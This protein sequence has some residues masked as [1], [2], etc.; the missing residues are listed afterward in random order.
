[1]EPIKARLVNIDGIFGQVK[2][3]DSQTYG[4]YYT[5]RFNAEEKNS[6]GIVTQKTEES[7]GLPSYTDLPM[8]LD[9]YFKI[10]LIQKLDGIE[11]A[12][13]GLSPKTDVKFDMPSLQEITEKVCAKL[14]SEMKLKGTF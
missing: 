8:D 9:T 12:L 2:Y 4:E 3:V 13:A 6:D 14:Y 11:K 1:M 5:S 7:W 10:A